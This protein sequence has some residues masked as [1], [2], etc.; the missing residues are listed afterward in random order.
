MIGKGG[1]TRKRIEAETQ[2][3]LI[4]PKFGDSGDVGKK[5]FL[6]EFF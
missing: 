5:I 2:T 6:N 4:I 3:A 1:E